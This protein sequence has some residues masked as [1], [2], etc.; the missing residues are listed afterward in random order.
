[1]TDTRPS[2]NTDPL[3]AA[4]AEY[5]RTH[6]GW[7]NEPADAPRGDNV[8]EAVE[9]LTLAVSRPDGYRHLRTEDLIGLAQANATLA[10]VEAQRDTNYLLGRIFDEMQS[11]R[12]VV[13]L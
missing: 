1:M 5:G 7:T 4:A 8:V 12:R 13:G 6:L 2:E 3:F 9:N 11:T 10:L